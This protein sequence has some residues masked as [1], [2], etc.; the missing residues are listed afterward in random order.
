MRVANQF[1]EMLPRHETP[2]HTEGYEG[3]YHLTSMEGNVE[4]SNPYLH[5]QRSRS[6]SF[7]E[8]V[9]KR[10]SIWS[11]RSIPNFRVCASVELKDQYFNMR[12]KIEPVMHI[13]AIA[14]EAMKE[15]GVKTECESHS[16]GEPMGH[17]CRSKDCLARI[18]LQVAITSTAVSNMCPFHQYRKRWM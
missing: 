7:R 2:E 6:R 9:K 16:R 1:V 3:F 13:V 4:K 5:Y 15:V 10:C 18:S 11:I 14:E 12:E 8:N 17:S